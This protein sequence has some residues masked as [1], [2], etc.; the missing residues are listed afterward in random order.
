MV[1][2]KRWA[3]GAV[4]NENGDGK[5]R[6]ARGGRRQ[7]PRVIPN[8]DMEH[9]TWPEGLGALTKCSHILGWKERRYYSAQRGAGVPNGTDKLVIMRLL[10]RASR[11][12]CLITIPRGQKAIPEEFD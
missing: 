9:R 10:N 4:I 2:S 3:A 12:S 5:A 7:G 8:C 11:E 1:Q 6:V